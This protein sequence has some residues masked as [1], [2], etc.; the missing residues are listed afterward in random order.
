MSNGLTVQV[1]PNQKNFQPLFTQGIMRDGRL[2]GYGHSVEQFLETLPHTY[3]IY[4]IVKLQTYTGMFKN[5]LFHG[6][7]TCWTRFG[8]RECNKN[9]SGVILL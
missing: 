6:F 4:R 8:S 5:G 3:P 1:Y 7:G 2:N 9:Y